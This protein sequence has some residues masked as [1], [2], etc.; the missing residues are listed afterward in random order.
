M[1]VVVAAGVSVLAWAL[2]PKARK[3][4]PHQNSA[5]HQPK[6]P[7]IDGTGKYAVEVVGESHYR[8][9]FE[10]L[11]GEAA[12][13]DRELTGDAVLQLQD[14]N[15]HDDQAVAV[16]VQGRQVGHLTRDMARTFRKALKR[17]G[18][19]QLRE[20]AVGCRIYGGGAEGHF[21]VWLDLPAV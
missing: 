18:F 12:Y 11:L 6:F 16:F 2:R 14:N 15:P 3:G 17:D 20:V 10:A 7:R 13:T 9:S 5:D 8:R 4:H 1:L 21:S 19:G